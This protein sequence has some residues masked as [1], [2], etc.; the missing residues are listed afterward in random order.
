METLKVVVFTENASNRLSLSML[1]KI[2]TYG[3]F[4]VLYVYTS[5]LYPTVGINVELGRMSTCASGKHACTIRD[6]LHCK[7][8]NFNFSNDITIYILKLVLF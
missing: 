7:N 6:Q 3:C 1:A 8:I 2:G 5:E 4:R